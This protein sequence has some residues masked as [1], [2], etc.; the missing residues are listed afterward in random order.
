MGSATYG[1]NCKAPLGNQTRNLAVACNGRA[2]CAYKIDC[3]VIGDPAVGCGKNYVAEW[4]CGRNSEVHR[5]V[6]N[7][8]AGFGSMINLGCA[9]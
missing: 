4:R 6:A 5:V 9:R 8:E 2:D 3:T 1:S 7:P